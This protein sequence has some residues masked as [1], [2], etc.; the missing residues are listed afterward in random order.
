M[1]VRKSRNKSKQ[2]ALETEVRVKELEEENV[3]LQ[4]KIALLLKEL[5]V[6]KNLFSSSDQ[7]MTTANNGTSPVSM[8]KS[9][10]NNGGL[11]G[12]SS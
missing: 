12:F 8:I 9:E 3:A 10:V 1:A 11:T 2:R 7:S 5:N 6:L 4:N